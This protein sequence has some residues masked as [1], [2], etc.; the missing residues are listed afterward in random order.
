[1]MLPMSPSTAARSSLEEMLDA[2][3]KRDENEK[4]KDLPPALPSRP[5]SKARRPS[6]RWQLLTNME[7]D[8]VAAADVSNTSSLPE[9][10]LNHST[11]RAES[12]RR[13][14]AGSFG[15]Q[16]DK[17]LPGESPYVPMAEEKTKEKMPKQMEVQT[18]AN[19]NH[20]SSSKSR[21][22][23]SECGDN[24]CYFIKKK[25]HVW[26]RLPNRR[27]ELGQI[28][29]TLGEKAAIMLSDGTVAEVLK[30]DLLPANPDILEAVDDLIQLS[31]LNEPSVLHNLQCRYSKDIIYSKA[32]CVLIAINPF[33]D[34][35]CY[36][37]DFITA[38]REKLF[39]NP[40]VYAIADTA[41]NE[42]MRDGINQSII[43]SGESGAGKTETAKV[44]MQYLAAIGDGNS[45]I[46]SEILQ[47]SSILEAF[48]NAKTVRNDNSSRF[49]KLIEIHFSATG[50]ICGAQIQ[51]FLLEKSRV[52]Q[53]AHQERS[54]H[55]FY[56][57]CAGAS[58]DLKAQ[59]NLKTASE[60]NYLNQSQC[61]NIDGI[62]DAHSFKRLLEALHTVKIS[63]D[64]QK[65]SFEM[66]AA[67]LWLGNISFQVDNENHAEVVADEAVTTSARLLGCSNQDLMAALST[68]R[69]LAGK[70]I[71]A[72]KLTM[73][74]AID[75]RD[76][77]AKFIYGSLFDWLVEEMNKSLKFG[78]Q[79]TGRSISILDIYG[80]ESLKKNSFE[81]LCINYANERLQQHF[82][83]H[84]FKL[85]QEEYDFE[86]I[87][88]TKVAFVDNQECL[89]LFEKKPIGLLSL[90]DE[91]SKF[92][93][94][95]DLTFGNK[96]KQHLSN[97]PHFKGERSS[98]FVIRHYAGEVLYDTNGFLEK[99]RD[100]L[101]SDILQLLS[102][103][104]N[105]L[106]QLFGSCILNH[107][108][109]PD[110]SM[111]HIGLI[112]PQKQSVG[113]KFKNQLFKLMQ[114][115]EGSTPHFIRCIKPNNK[116]LS[117]V[118]EKDLVLEQ[119]RYGGILEVVR[120]SRYGYPTRV[121]HQ[122]FARRYAF[123][124]PDDYAGE[125]PL[126]TSIAILQQFDI[127]PEM[128]QV[129]YTKLYFRTGQISAIEDTRKQLLQGTL[130]M[131]K[132]FRG[133]RARRHFSELKKGVITMQS[134]I[135]SENARRE[136]VV[137]TKLKQKAAQKIIDDRISAITLV[138]SV[139]RGWLTRKHVG[140][141]Q[142]LKSINPDTNKQTLRKNSE[143]KVA[144][145]ELIQVPPSV[146]EMLHKRVSEAEATVAQKE[147]ENVELKRHLQQY[148]SKWLDYES[149][150]N[151][152]EEKWKRQMEALQVNLDEARKTLS[153]ENT[154][155]NQQQ[156]GRRDISPYD[157]ED[158]MSMG[159]PTP[160]P[161]TPVNNSNISSREPNGSGAFGNM[162]MEFEQQRHNFEDEAKAINN[163]M[164]SRHP[165]D[166]F[167]KLK[168]RFEMWK[169]DYKT[170]L[171]ETKVK[172]HRVAHSDTEKGRRK[173]W[174]RSK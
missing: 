114:Q 106:P 89:D 116:K 121:T 91:E 119:L 59:L 144:T 11:T 145:Q 151:A 155:S 135:R 45:G 71:V 99:N 95:T 82:T 173:W 115:L 73:Q 42:M 16:K 157:S 60:Y 36:G 66:L 86:G 87:D 37:S 1:M 128:Y 47:T 34:V 105:R 104:G 165:D 54:Y 26:G 88:W 56:Q 6:S 132:R 65:Q 150:M 139:I 12:K 21:V 102:S 172:F 28:T 100:P 81:Q 7:V 39:E 166:E 4:S 72:K 156:S 108:Q 153:G 174:K 10:N 8:V 58:S 146:L 111:S 17:E 23:E 48:G 38:F 30:A 167:R 110:T 120:I 77:L 136:W 118:Y 90:L 27:W 93:K 143:A 147:H 134:F 57:L 98:A 74:Q 97:N 70:D 33:K 168:L 130:K 68:Y 113:T 101:H 154:T 149:K 50:N 3:R 25:L 131:Q 55:I 127:L 158:G 5:S 67:V 84:L 52:V 29:S 49:G 169:K 117:G 94:A 161:G 35:N 14:R 163:N 20:N 41:Y 160:L 125:D 31:Y 170:R 123:L 159:P 22:Q 107:Q 76:A 133:H 79:Y 24:I 138:Q 51:T 13:P 9:N 83:R 69:I 112:D 53:L 126:S 19:N 2:L 43:I 96:L 80:F 64:D 142:N 109:K 78:K 152:M 75:S 164:A 46:E 32:G 162:E 122:E 63:K 148:E 124:L 18:L 140:D 92:P 61:L 141:L 103:C 15:G 137:L 129:G 171:K 40:H 62:D 44:A 85:E